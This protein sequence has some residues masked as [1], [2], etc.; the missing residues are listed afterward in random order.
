MTDTNKRLV[1]EWHLPPIDCTQGGL[2]INRVHI[3]Y[4]KARA[5]R[6]EAVIP[7][8]APTREAPLEEALQRLDDWSRA[9]PLKNFPEPDFA[10]AAKLLK[11]GGMSLDAIG[12][13]NM[14]H[15]IEGVGEIARAALASSP[16]PVP[17]TLARGDEI[18]SDFYMLKAQEWAVEP[19]VAKQLVT[20]ALA[21]SPAPAQSVPHV[22]IR[23]NEDGSIDEVIA[24]GCDLCVEQMSADGWY[25]GLY[26]PDG[27]YWQFWFGAKNRKSHVEFLHT[28]H[29][30]PKQPTSPASDSA[31]MTPH[32]G[33]KSHE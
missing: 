27:D 17:S 4:W 29:S 23:K 15:A 10:K 21:S 6:A 32:E 12:A 5:E 9:Y 20:Q 18:E 3:D 16:A 31:A 14:R 8:P 2:V 22:E 28:E 7:S 11:A 13:S 26:F 24:K 19:S 1:E 25:M 33:Q 30:P